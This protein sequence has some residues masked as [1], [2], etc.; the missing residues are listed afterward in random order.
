MPTWTVKFEIDCMM[1]ACQTS[2][3]LLI[4]SNRMGVIV[5]VE[6]VRSLDA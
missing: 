5:S 6:W 4:L 1:T 3:E 2:W